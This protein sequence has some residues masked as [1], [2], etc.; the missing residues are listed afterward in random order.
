MRFWTIGQFWWESC[1]YTI[2]QKQ[3]IIIIIIIIIMQIINVS[4]NLKFKNN[5]C[6]SSKY[7]GLYGAPAPLVFSNLITGKERILFLLKGN[8]LQAL[9]MQYWSK[10][11]LKW[12]VLI[13]L[14]I[15]LC[16]IALYWNKSLQELCLRKPWTNKQIYFH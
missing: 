7:F 2:P 9:C 8:Q 13:S 4:L 1:N 11:L 10:F 14:S 5:V 15:S 3:F 12:K 16:C 6:S